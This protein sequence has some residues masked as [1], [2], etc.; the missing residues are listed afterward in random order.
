MCWSPS[1]EA[2]RAWVF[3]RQS[4]SSVASSSDTFPFISWLQSLNITTTSMTSRPMIFT[5]YYTK[6]YDF[7]WV[8]FARSIWQKNAKEKHVKQILEK[9][10]SSE[11]KQNDI[12]QVATGSYT[13]TSW[14][15]L[16]SAG[17]VRS[18][19]WCNTFPRPLVPE[20]SHQL[21]LTHTHPHTPSAWHSSEAQQVSRFHSKL[22]FDELARTPN[23]YI[24][25]TR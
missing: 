6:N 14:P 19:E 21:A 3:V 4:E 18:M 25:H 1:C 8:N 16:P 5:H 13:H 23:C 9:Y 24:Q 7:G 11:S 22:L 20:A 12:Q 15:D 2:R 10:V 17:H